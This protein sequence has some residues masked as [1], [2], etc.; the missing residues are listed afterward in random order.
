[1]TNPAGNIP[2]WPDLIAEMGLLRRRVHEVNDIHPFT[3]PHFAATQNQIV[4]AE[5]RLGDALD[6]Q[7]RDFLSYANGWPEFYLG[8]T[9]LSTE[10]LGQGQTWEEL[11]QTLDAFCSSLGD[12]SVIPPR[13]QIYPITYPEEGSSIFA[14]WK[15]GP[16]T[17]GGHPVLW[18]PWR[19]SE[20]YD[21]FFEF[22]R[23][24]YQEYEAELEHG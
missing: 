19:D 11:N 21:N 2:P 14:I 10:Q 17:D 3:I 8:S 18:L 13:N 7:H 12:P 15:D 16:V 23:V 4:A 1:M 20:P 6:P 24:T 22:F 9:L 5:R